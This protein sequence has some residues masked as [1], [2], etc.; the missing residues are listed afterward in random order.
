[1]AAAR[2]SSWRAVW[3]CWTRSVVRE[4]RDPVPGLDEGV[5][6]GSAQMRL[7]DPGRSERQDIGAGIEPAIALGERRDPGTAD[8]RHRDEVERVERLADRQT[9]FGE[10]PGGAAV[11]AFGDLVLEQR[12]ERARGRPAL[13]VGG[14]ADVGP[15]PGDGGQAE[16]G[17][18]QREACGIGG[19]GHAASSPHRPPSSGS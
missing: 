19:E 18:Q 2:R 9:R 10:M 8:H 16:G 12:G 4:N 7:A 11:G 5:A 15:E 13:V 17:E 14:R 6:E 1:M 3:S